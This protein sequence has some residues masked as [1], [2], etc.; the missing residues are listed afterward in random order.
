MLFTILFWAAIA[1]PILGI[2][3]GAISFLK[4]DMGLFELIAMGFAFALIPILIVSIVWT[5]YAGDIATIKEQER[6]ISVYEQQRDD[7]KDTIK[8]FAFPAGALMNAD[9]PVASIVEELANAERYLASARNVKAMAYRSIEQTRLGIM[10]GVIDMVG[11][12]P[13]E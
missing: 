12:L 5:E 7:I 11:E 13:E 2:V 3:L 4:F 10:S 1:F 9:S 8:M 6:I